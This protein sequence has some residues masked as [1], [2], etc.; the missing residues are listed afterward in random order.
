MRLSCRCLVITLVLALS[1]CAQ[2]DTATITGRVTDSTGATIAN[3][4][5]KVV[6]KETNFQFAAVT[7]SD[8]LFRVQ[9]LQ[10]GTYQ[11]TLEAAGF[12]RMV[13]D[14]IILRVGD[15]LPV[16][17]ELQVGAVTESVEVTAQSTLLET[18]TSSQARSPK[19]TRCTRRRCINATSPTP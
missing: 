7:N 6:Q 15:V 9:S 2:V 8:G 17:A 18:E 14:G 4:Q 13:Q 10:P 19:A 11:V 5:V 16:N 12:K 1:V 3:A